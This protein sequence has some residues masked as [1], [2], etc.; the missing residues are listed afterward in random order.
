MENKEINQPENQSE[1]K[2]SSIFNQSTLFALMSNIKNASGS[3]MENR[4]NDSVTNIIKSLDSSEPLK[5]SKKS[6]T[7]SFG[8]SLLAIGNDSKTEMFSNYSFTNDTLNWPLWLAL[9]NDSWVFARAIDKPA[10]DCVKAGITIQGEVQDKNAINKSI[11]LYRDDMIQLF[12][13][14]RLFGG[15]IAVVMFD[16]FQDDDYSKPLQM[17]MKKIREAKVMKLYVVDRWYGV[18]PDY[19]KTV[20]K[21]TS[22][23]YGKPKFYNITMP[24]GKSYRYRY[25]YIIR[26]EHRIAPKLVKNGMLQGWGYSEG[27]HILNELARDEKLKTSIQSLVDKSLI[28]VIKMSGMRG[29]FMGADKENE[30]Q[31]RKRLE[32]V[33]WGRSFN[34]LTFLDKDDEYQEHGFS[35]LTG[36]SDLLEQNMWMIAAALEMQGVLF[37]DLKGGMVSDITALER[38]DEVIQGICESYCRKPYQKL[39]GF[40]YIMKG[41]KEKPEFT[42]NSLLMKK[43][44]ADRIE[45]IK[46]FTELCRT[47]LDSGV[48]NTKQFAKALQN[49]TDKGEVDFGLTDDVIDK[50]E[51][52]FGMELEGLDFEKENPIIEGGTD[53]NREGPNK[54]RQSDIRIK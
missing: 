40:I 9:Y 52:S 44:D 24:N 35:G 4:L 41:V 48:I 21:M 26:Y 50:M 30:E 17:N 25:D 53:E 22:D 51:E 33:N 16:N 49:Y 47:L 29:V 3:E 8:N 13:W 7:D 6:V 42:F 11:K 37:G 2:P 32:M 34:S 5:A 43:Q 54:T 1:T 20:N 27:S 38:Y 18:A 15:S 14:G 46:N 19:N 45:G 31:L 12:T 23:D 28:E 39:L 36:L 10:Q